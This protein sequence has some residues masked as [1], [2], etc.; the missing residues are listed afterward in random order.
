MTMSTR[1]DPEV[2]GPAFARW[3]AQQ[4]RAERAVVADLVHPSAGYS[5]ETMLVDVTWSAEGRSHDERLVIRMAPPTAGTFGDYDL[6]AQGRAQAA[7]A[8]AGI[9]VANPVVE[10]DPGWLGAP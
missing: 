4:R 2:I 5:S 7:A 3:I 1:R 8:A 10:A 6:L 9:P